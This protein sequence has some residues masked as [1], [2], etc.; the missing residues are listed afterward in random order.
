MKI[1]RAEPI[2]TGTDVF[3]KIETDAGLVGYGD[4]QRCRMSCESQSQRGFSEGRGKSLSEK[5]ARHRKAPL[6]Q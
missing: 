4:A 1:T 2:L 5:Q 6:R 3:I